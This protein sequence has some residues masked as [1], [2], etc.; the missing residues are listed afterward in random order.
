MAPDVLR[1][2]EIRMER[3][4]IKIEPEWNNAHCSLEGVDYDLPGW[5][6]LPAAFQSVWTDHGPFVT[7]TTDGNGVI[8]GM[9]ACEE[10][11]PEPAPEPEGD[12]VW[13]EMAGAIR[14]GVN[15]V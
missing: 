8:T 6:E 15:E 3:T 4:I 14:E 10:I 12:D 2:E 7:I 1:G 13:S 9:E 5:A 11:V